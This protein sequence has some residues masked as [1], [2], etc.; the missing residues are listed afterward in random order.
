MGLVF[1]VW[2]VLST[3]CKHS[4]LVL[5]FFLSGGGAKCNNAAFNFE[6]ISLQASHHQTSRNCT[7]VEGLCIL[8]GFVRYPLMAV[9]AINKSKVVATS[10]FLSLVIMMSRV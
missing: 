10:S 5:S 2:N 8:F 3:E 7:E 1:Q 9:C 4:H 6:R